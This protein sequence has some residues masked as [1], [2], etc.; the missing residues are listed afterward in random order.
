M[1]AGYGGLRVCFCH[2]HGH[3]MSVPV[4]VWMLCN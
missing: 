2:V 4:K 1:F 3:G